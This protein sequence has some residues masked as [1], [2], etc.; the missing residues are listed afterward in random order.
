V[1]NFGGF[2][3]E[4]GDMPQARPSQQKEFTGSVMNG[5]PSLSLLVFIGSL[6]RVHRA[7]EGKL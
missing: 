7:T 2:V 3:R 4:S 6:E 1:N 5:G